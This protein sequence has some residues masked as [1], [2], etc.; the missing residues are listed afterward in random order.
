MIDI[1]DENKL[2]SETI[3]IRLHNFNKNNMKKKQILPYMAPQCTIISM[4][5][6]P[7]LMSGSGSEKPV[8]P[9]TPES[10]AANM[11]IVQ[12]GPGTSDTPKSDT[13]TDPS[14][15]DWDWLK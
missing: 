8:I 12:W 5:D 2:L 13:K 11:G 9:A 3:K 1:D 15:A 7:M 6:V 4:D 10:P 14:D